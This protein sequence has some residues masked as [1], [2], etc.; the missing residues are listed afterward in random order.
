MAQLVVKPVETRRERRQFLELPWI[1]YARDPHWIPPLRQNQKEL[2]GYRRHPF[3]IDNKIQTFLATRNGEPCGRV[4]A[5]L[6]HAHNERHN[7]RRGFFGFF[8]SVDD[9]EVATGLL[10]AVRD[11]FAQRD[12]RAV[13]GPCNP[14][15]NY[16]AGLLVDGFDASPAFMMTYNPPYY[17]HLVE[18]YGFRKSHDLFAYQG[19]A[20][21]LETVGGRLKA[22]VQGSSERTGVTVRRLD[23][24]RML[25]EIRVFVDVFNRSMEGSWG[26]VPLTEPELNQMAHTFRYLVAPELAVTAEVDGKPIGV[27]LALPDYNPR[28]K[29]ID[30]R[31]FPLG[32]IRLLRNRKRIKR[33]RVICANVL[34]EYQMSGVGVVIFAKIVNQAV[35]WGV[36]EGEFSWVM[37]SNHLSRMS[38]EHGG[39]QKAKT[40][41]IYDYANGQ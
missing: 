32:F 20:E 41:R 14:S 24:S 22:V 37:E 1:I 7:D 30:G 9:R 10:D 16:E 26:H 33:I 39:A 2:V 3:H 38:L 21:L 11:W 27:G 36:E 25:D 34:P 17:E 12:V 28:I 8:E 35:A 23:T 29:R 18:D 19:R 5:I 31:L 13:R 4:A 6:N 40:Y 15:L